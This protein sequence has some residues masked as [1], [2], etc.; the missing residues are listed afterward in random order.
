ME[1]M[2]KKVITCMYCKRPMIILIEKGEI[3]GVMETDE[4]NM[5]E[6]LR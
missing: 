5:E 4:K 2:K 6:Q 1:Q 3:A